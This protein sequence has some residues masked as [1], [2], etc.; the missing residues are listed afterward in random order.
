M[1]FNA[2][3]L[4]DFKESKERRHERT[5]EESWEDALEEFQRKIRNISN[6]FWN[7][8]KIHPPSF[9][10]ERI[11]VSGFGV[12]GVGGE[13]E[14]GEGGARGEGEGEGGERGRVNS[15]KIEKRISNNFVKKVAIFTQAGIEPRR[16]PCVVIDEVHFAF[17]SNSLLPSFRQR[18]QS[19]CQRLLR[20]RQHGRC[21]AS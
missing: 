8:S 16:F 6:C 15:D 2:Y 11:S 4:G 10:H 18:S 20:S 17:R 13:E 3:W 12:G 21:I 9:S 14:G 19:L 1:S 5:L 7:R